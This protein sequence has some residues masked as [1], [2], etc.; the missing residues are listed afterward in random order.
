MTVDID[1]MADRVAK[2]ALDEYTY[3]GKTIREW[4]ELMVTAEFVVEVRMVE[5]LEKIKEEMEKQSNRNFYENGW[6]TY[7]S[8]V[9]D[10]HISELKGEK[11]E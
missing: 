6:W 2:K 11:N 1:K 5:E 9:F 10:K 7:V 8:S 4:V 3:N